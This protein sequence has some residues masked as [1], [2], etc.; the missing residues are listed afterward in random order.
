[1]DDASSG[2]FDDIDALAGVLSAYVLAHVAALF[3]AC[4]T[5]RALE[6]RHQ[7]A[8]VSQMPPE[9]F[10]HCVT[11]A[12]LWAH[13]ISSAVSSTAHRCPSYTLIR[14]GLH[15]FVR[16]DPVISVQKPKGALH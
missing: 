16:V 3:A 13:V 9:A 11:V 8:F 7:A 15:R 10:D 2:R 12:A 6:S 14:V 4:A 1:M 5:V